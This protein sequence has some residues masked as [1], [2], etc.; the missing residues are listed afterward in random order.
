M[1]SDTLAGTPGNLAGTPG[2]QIAVAVYEVKS[3][4]SPWQSPETGAP[5]VGNGVMWLMSTAYNT[6]QPSNLAFS[7]Y[8]N[9]INTGPAVTGATISCGADDYAYIVLNGV[10]YPSTNGNMSLGYEG[11]QPTASFTVNIPPGLN[12]LE[13][14]AVNAGPVVNNTWQ[15]QGQMGGPTAAWLAITTGT[16]VLVKTTNKWRCTEFNYP[17][18]FIGPVSLGDVA[19]NAG[20]SRPYSLAALTLAGRTLYNNS[21]MPPHSLCRSVYLQLPLRHSFIHHERVLSSI[22]DRMETGMPGM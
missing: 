10:K 16:T 11:I 21:K 5:D 8:Y 2:N 17:G 7:F 22:A 12:T 20:L 4:S 1:G 9:F 13:L 6:N 15:N 14:R 19:E 3:A 18:K